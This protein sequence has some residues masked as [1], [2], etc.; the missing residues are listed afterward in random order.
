MLNRIV[1][2]YIG[3]RIIISDEIQIFFSYLSGTTFMS[4]MIVYKTCRQTNKGKNILLS[5][6]ANMHRRR[7]RKKKE[8]I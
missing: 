8:K 1:R 5:E 7:R 2:I 4:T 6:A 3:V